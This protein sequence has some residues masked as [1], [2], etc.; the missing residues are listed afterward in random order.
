MLTHLSEKLQIVRVDFFTIEIL[1]QFRISVGQSQQNGLPTFGCTTE[2]T[3]PIKTVIGTQNV[4]VKKKNSAN[5]C[6]F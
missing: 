1:D 4:L 2:T 5:Q 6:V 3:L